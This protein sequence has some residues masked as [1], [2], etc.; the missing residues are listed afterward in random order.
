MPEYGGFDFI[1]TRRP[2]NKTIDCV[3]NFKNQVSQ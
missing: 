1:E 2:S 3:D